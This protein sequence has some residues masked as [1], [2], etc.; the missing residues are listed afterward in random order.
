MSSTDQ[1]MD[2]LIKGCAKNDRKS[3]RLLY[4]KYYSKML[5]TCLRY[6]KNSDEA[7]DILQ[8]GFIKVFTSLPNYQST[9]SLDAWIKRIMVNTA[10]DYYRKRQKDEYITTDSDYILN[11][12]ESVFSEDTSYE[13]DRGFQNM[14]PN[15]VLEAIQELSPSY[16]MVF[17]LFVME[18]NSHKQI[19][20]S[21]GISEGTSKSNLAKAKANLQQKLSKYIIKQ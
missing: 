3:Q 2:D 13:E 10:L 14:D 1:N 16:R 12:D 19:A 17:N 20:E 4:E 8:E 6:T 15:L 5:H 18:G 11:S 21:L 9:G 7:R